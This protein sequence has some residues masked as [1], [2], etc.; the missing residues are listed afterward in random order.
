MARRWLES[1]AG[2]PLGATHKGHRGGIAC[3][4]VVKDDK[5]IEGLVTRDR[6]QEELGRD[7]ADWIPELIASRDELIARGD[8]EV[9]K[10]CGGVGARTA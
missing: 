7:E 9:C 2:S 6:S 3:K 8:R 1:R 4:E 5:A 10:Q